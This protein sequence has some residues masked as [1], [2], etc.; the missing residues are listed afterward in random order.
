[1]KFGIALIIGFTTLIAG[2]NCD[3]TSTSEAQLPEVEKTVQILKSFKGF[4][5]AGVE[6]SVCTPCGSDPE[7]P[8]LNWLVALNDTAK[9][10]HKEFKEKKSKDGRIY[11]EFKGIRKLSDPND[12]F[13]LDY[14]YTVFLNV[15]TLT[16]ELTKSNCS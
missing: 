4:Y 3:R 9:R 6:S 2:C 10:L 15:L 14:K 13:A 11:I 1:M 8:T 12:Y 5:Y 7:D 16:S